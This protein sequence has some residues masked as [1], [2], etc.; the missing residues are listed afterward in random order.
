MVS[1]SN[2]SSGDVHNMVVGELACEMFDHYLVHFSNLRTCGRVPG[3]RFVCDVKAFYFRVYDPIR[4]TS[5][6]L[7]TVLSDSIGNIRIL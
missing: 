6:P 2:F 3:R 4:K 5:S 1:R 7:K